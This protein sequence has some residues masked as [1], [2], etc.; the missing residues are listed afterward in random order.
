LPRTRPR[1]WTEKRGALGLE[2]HAHLP[3]VTTDEQLQDLLPDRWIDG[4]PEHRLVHREKQAS[5][6]KHH[7]RQR[8]AGRRELRQA[9]AK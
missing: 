9:E 5:Q 1:I 3:E 4:H 8:R 6:E 7:R 2:D